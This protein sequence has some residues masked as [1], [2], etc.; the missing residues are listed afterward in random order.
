MKQT[1]KILGILACAFMYSSMYLLPYIKYIFYDAVEEVTGFTNTQI[2]FCLSVYIIASIICTLPSGWLADKYPPKKLL[3]LSG[4]GHTILSFLALLF[5]RNYAMTLVL[6]FGMGIT[7]V[8]GFWSPVFK[9]VS[10]SGKQEEQGKYYGWF[11]GLNGVGSMIFNFLALWIFSR[12]T[13]GSA[14]ALA[15]VYIFYT[16]ASLISV[17]MVAFMY[18]PE[19]E[20]VQAEAKRAAEAAPHKKASTKEIL[21]VLKMPKVWLF[22]L[23][24]MGIYG[25]YAGSSYL[26]PYFSTVLGVSIVF[27]GSLATLKNYGTRLVGAPI[28][29]HIC[30]KIGR[31]KFLVIAAAATVVLMI[32]FMMMPANNSAL[33]PI[34]ILMFAMALVNVS[35]K[36]VQF[37]A[38]DEVGVDQSI[39][40]MAIAVASLIGFNLPDVAL[41]PLFGMFLDKYEAVV[42]YKMIFG[43]LLGLLVLGFVMSLLLLLMHKKDLAKAEAAKVAQAAAK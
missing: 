3:V 17:L 5:I 23:M 38:L 29:G 43:F 1:K 7:S 12:I 39:N 11:E 9:A 20:A 30:D 41:H 40:G 19:L 13:S 14:A 35:M 25:F 10:M 37:S 31:L 2:G 34:M 18:K 15:G 33:I 21:A 27:S 16:C 26:T 24:V 8:L 6:F 28:A 32:I 4:I 36:G 22:S 42:A